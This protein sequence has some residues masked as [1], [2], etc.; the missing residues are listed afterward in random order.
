MV[1]FLFL[2]L[3][4]YIKPNGSSAMTIFL[5]NSL[6]IKHQPKKIRYHLGKKSYVG[7]SQSLHLLDNGITQLLLKQNL[8]IHRNIFVMFILYFSPLC[9]LT[10]MMRH[11]P[12]SDGGDQLLV[13]TE[14][15]RSKKC[16]VVTWY[17]SPHPIGIQPAVYNR[18]FNRNYSITNMKVH[19]RTQ[20]KVLNYK[21]WKC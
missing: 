20:T 3:K 13:F 19:M 16:L 7:I 12:W 5:W 6:V 10:W 17:D 9:V 8:F 14:V 11:S 18:T 2:Y 1:K 4:I 21:V 15:W